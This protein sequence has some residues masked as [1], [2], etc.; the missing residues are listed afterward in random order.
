MRGEPEAQRVIRDTSPTALR[1]PLRPSRKTGQAQRAPVPSQ[2]PA[3]PHPAATASE[4]ERAPRVGPRVHRG[5]GPSWGSASPSASAEET[6]V[7]SPFV[8][9]YAGGGPGGC[10]S[11]PLCGS[12]QAPRRP[13]HRPARTPYGEAREPEGAGWEGGRRQATP[14][15]PHRSPLGGGRPSTT[16]PAP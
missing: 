2:L 12:A 13:R 6:K 4:R 14:R 7:K 1:R 9:E 11:R 15:L 5:D 8:G 10:I 3:R 16:T